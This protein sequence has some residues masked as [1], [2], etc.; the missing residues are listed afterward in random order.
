MVGVGREKGGGY[1]KV[2]SR[3]GISAAAGIRSEKV[4]SVS[5]NHQQNTTSAGRWYWWCAKMPRNV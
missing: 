4:R 2:G 5:T 3:T 1:G